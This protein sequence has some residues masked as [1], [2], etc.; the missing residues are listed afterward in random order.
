VAT[1]T[2]GERFAVYLEEG[3][4]RGGKVPMIIRFAD[5]F[6]R[7]DMA[8]RG[9]LFE[10]WLSEHA[11]ACGGCGR[12]FAPDNRRTEEDDEILCRPCREG[13]GS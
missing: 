2:Y 9:E 1:W 10:E 4:V 6:E 12:R 11:F 8:V 5:A 7:R 3:L 13:R